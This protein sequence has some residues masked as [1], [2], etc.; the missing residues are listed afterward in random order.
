MFSVF[1]G[2]TPGLRLP[3]IPPPPCPPGA[4]EPPREGGPG[5]R[6]GGK[7]VRQNAGQLRGVPELLETWRSVKRSGGNPCFVQST[8]SAHFYQ[9]FAVSP[10]RTQQNKYL[11]AF[12]AARDTPRNRKIVEMFRKSRVF[13]VKTV[14]ALWTIRLYLY[15]EHLLKFVRV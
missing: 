3:C 13:R 5:Y 10:Y 12:V 2:L 6:L 14:L 15:R 7:A 9:S 11:V 8:S 1:G 4:D